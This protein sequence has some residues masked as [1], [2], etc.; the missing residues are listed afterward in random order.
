MGLKNLSKF[1]IH[2]LN[3]G[4]VYLLWGPKLNIFGL[5]SLTR[6]WKKTQTR[7]LNL[8]F[9]KIDNLNSKFVVRNAHSTRSVKLGQVSRLVRLAR[10]AR[11]V[12]LVVFG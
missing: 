5:P 12:W 8:T 2:T 11:L 3:H 4:L 1:E 10:L 6:K 7:L 9:I